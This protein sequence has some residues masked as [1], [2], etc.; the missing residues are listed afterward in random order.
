[1]ERLVKKDCIKSL[2][3]SKEPTIVYSL[4]EEAEAIANACKSLGINVDAF[5]D[6]EIRKSQKPYCG[7]EVIFTP[8]LTKRLLFILL[9]LKNLSVSINEIFAANYN[10]II[11]LFSISS[12]FN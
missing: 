4:T 8:D 12:I 5:C 1:M 6:N 2:L 9:L 3:S 10:N 11:F 7:K